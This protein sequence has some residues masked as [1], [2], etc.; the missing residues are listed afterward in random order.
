VGA[1]PAVGVIC[2]LEKVAILV[3][4]KSV[5]FVEDNCV[6]LD[7]NSIRPGRIEVPAGARDD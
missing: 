5:N 2:S 7:R 6:G 3:L 4:S 1:L